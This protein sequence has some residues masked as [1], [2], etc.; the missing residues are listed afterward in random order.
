MSA[1]SRS[2]DKPELVFAL[3]GP[4]GTRLDDLADSL[5]SRLEYFGY[6]CIDIR[7]SKLL[8]DNFSWDSPPGSSEFERISHLQNKGDALR[9]RLKDGA[10]LARASI[11]EI[12]KVR[13]A[14]T[15]HPDRPASAHAYILRQLKHPDE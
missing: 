2:V 6:E 14:K 5:K 11:A 8:E 12:R 9:E 13:M 4:A 1:S 3:V 15:G 10:A 7:L